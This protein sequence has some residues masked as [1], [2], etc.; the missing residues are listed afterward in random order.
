MVAVDSLK[1]L[2]ISL[3]VDVYD[4]KYQVSEV[5]RIIENNNFENVDAVIGPL[6]PNNFDRAASELRRNNIPI[7]SPIGE[8]LNLYDNVF[9]TRPSSELLRS[10]IVS[11]VKTMPEEKNI[12]II[13]DS[14]NTT[15]A[16]EI[17]Q[18]FTFARQV[19]SRK[20]KEGKDENYVLLDD[21]SGVLKPGLNMVFLE[22]QNE[23]FASNVTSILNSLIQEEN[24]EEKKQQIDI[25]LLTTNE[26]A[27]FEGD[28]I[29]NEHLSNLQF[30]FATMSKSI[31]SDSNNSFI[32]RYLKTYHITP[33]KRAIRGFDLTMDVVLRL[34]TSDDLYMSVKESPMTEYVETKFEYKKKLFGGFYNDTAY[35]VKYNDLRI[36]EVDLVN[37][38]PSEKLGGF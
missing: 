22:T 12:I 33:N 6:T 28:E 30:T 20:N 32:K 10:K 2:G 24:I 21:I 31:A 5:S 15:I 25:I 16:N 8:N 13:S 35:L 29:S 18:E 38:S 9:Q 4:T 19:G 7:V 26:N 14:K 34:V 36:V 3:K 1:K 37:E 23:G 11:Y 27:A 17:K